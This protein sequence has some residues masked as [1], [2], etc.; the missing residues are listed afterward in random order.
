VKS[1][2]TKTGGALA[3]DTLTDNFSGDTSKRSRH[4]S[5]GQTPRI[6]DLPD[7]VMT[8]SREWEG[9]QYCDFKGSAL[10]N[11][12]DKKPDPYTMLQSIFTA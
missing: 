9:N 1:V 7:T 3:T 2:K 8:S 11:E 10:M 5:D 6:T 12:L 4:A